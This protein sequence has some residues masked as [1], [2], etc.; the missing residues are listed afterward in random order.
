M[1]PDALKAGPQEAR[2]RLPSDQASAEE[3][4]I[5]AAYARR[6]GAWR[7]DWGNPA[8]VFTMYDLER[9][10]LAALRRAGLWPLGT[11]RILD[12][13]CGTGYWLQR[14]ISW[15]AASQYAAGIDLLRDRVRRA[16]RLCPRQIGLSCGSAL[17]LPFRSAS[18]DLELQFMVFSSILDADLRRCVADEMVRVL[19]GDGAILWYDFC[20][21]N[22]RNP[23]IRPIG[24]AEVRRL[25]PG[26]SVELNRVTLALPVTRLVAPVSW[27][28]CALLNLVP[29]L[30]TH[31]L[32]VIRKR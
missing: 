28:L 18:F 19:T 9:R 10:M 3:A 32:G 13:G 12:V 2:G 7:Y 15:G 26:C 17:A 20:V 25:F 23:D 21:P 8:Y 1:T 31:Y 24:L 27:A 16:A 11:K 4:R 6:G 22:P 5:R 30:R 14:L 29:L